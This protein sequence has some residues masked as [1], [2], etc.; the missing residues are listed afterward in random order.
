M[1]LLVNPGAGLHL[2]ETGTKDLRFASPQTLSET[3]KSLI[4]VNPMEAL[5]QGAMLQIIVFSLFFGIAAASRPQEAAPVM[6][7]FRSL[8]HIIMRM[9]I[10]L[11]HA[12][13][14]GVFALMAKTFATVGYAALVPLL[15][16]LLCVYGALAAHM[17]FTYGGAL[18]VIGRLSPLTFFH[19]L[20]PAMTVAFSTS[21]SNATL[22]VTIECVEKRCGVSPAIASFALPLGATINMDGT[23]IMQ[24][25]AVIFIAEVYGI[26]LSLT[27][28]LKVILTATLASI[29]TAGVPGVGMITLSMVLQSVNL[30]TQGIALIIGIDRIVDIA[31]TVVNV[32][33]DAV[34]TV[35]TAKSEGELDET[36]FHATNADE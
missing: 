4:P 25:V 21:S 30:P 1:G 7:I 31:R 20:I 10:L 16:Y 17:I 3:I 32:T 28:F 8:D 23:A 35:L 13:P 11:M 15:K 5:A 6:E 9:V 2:E 14:V 18:W 33:G 12:A 27:A 36:V 19:N 24:G 22:P 26:H 34:C 29:G